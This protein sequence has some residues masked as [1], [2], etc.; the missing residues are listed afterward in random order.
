MSDTVVAVM[1]VVVGVLVIAVSWYD[2]FHTLLNPS[3]R[4]TL[5][6]LV[7]ASSWRVA[8]RLRRAGGLVG[9]ASVVVII[10]LWAGL[11][12]VGWALV[13]LPSLPAGF[14]YAPGIDAENLWPFI[15]ALYFSAATLTTLGFG[16]LVPNE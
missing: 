11:Q 8:R 6:R 12:I 4:G 7:F 3:G 10:A 9:P 15:E 5:S 16:D 14:I 1:S 13:Y 2:V